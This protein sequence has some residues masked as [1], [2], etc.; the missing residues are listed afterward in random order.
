MAGIGPIP[1]LLH[2]AFI[3]ACASIVAG[4]YE[5]LPLP[6]DDNIVVTLTAAGILS[7]TWNVDITLQTSAISA[8]W[9]G[10]ALLINLSAATVAWWLRYVS[11]NGALGGALI[12][13]AILA[14]GGMEPYILLFVFFLLASLATRFGYHE[15]DLIGVAQKSEGRRNAKHAIAN[16]FF[17]TFAAVTIGMLEGADPLLQIFY[18][19]ALATAFGDTIASELGQIYGRSPFMASSF[20]LVPTGT[21]GA[22]SIEGTLL[23]MG[24][25]LLFAFLGFAVSMITLDWLPVVVIGAW[26]GFYAESYISGVWMEKG[27]EID[28]EWMNVVNTFIGGTVALLTAAVILSL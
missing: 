12:G 16:C 4:V 25:V 19:A 18:C 5:T 11:T 21:V 14:L 20:R 1:S 13:T 10:I 3:A 26:I 17:A 6:W 15:K 22:I 8:W 24:A 2:L 28:N 7:L 23:G 27:I 9:W